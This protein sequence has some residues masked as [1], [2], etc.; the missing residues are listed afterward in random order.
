[1]NLKQAQRFAEQLE[2]SLSERGL[3]PSGLE[4]LPNLDFGVLSDGELARLM[5]L[6]EAL[7]PPALP[8]V[9]Y[10]TGLVDGEEAELELLL[11]KIGFFGSE[12]V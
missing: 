11:G 5:E 2:K 1:M 9:R 6:L 3:L 8:G 10:E 4:A 7:A 12:T